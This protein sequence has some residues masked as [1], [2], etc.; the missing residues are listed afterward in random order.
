MIVANALPPAELTATT[1]RLLC[2]EIGFVNTARFLNQFTTGSGDYTEERE[3][4]F[5]AA[6]VDE[7]VAEIERKRSSGE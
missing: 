2:R 3:L 6:T 5:G 7:I 4:L 1:I